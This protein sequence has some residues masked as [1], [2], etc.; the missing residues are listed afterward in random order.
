MRRLAL[1]LAVLTLAAC[2]ALP[3]P[4]AA[5][6][7]TF[8]DK[9][10]LQLNVAKLEIEEAAGVEMVPQALPTASLAPADVAR[11]WARQRIATAGTQGVARFR[12]LEASVVDTTLPGT[13]HMGGFE[14]SMQERSLIA[15]LRVD[16]VLE[17]I[18][19]ERRALGDATAERRVH[20]TLSPAEREA[21]YDALLGDLAR[22]FDDVMT[23]QVGAALAGF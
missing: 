6:A 14:T 11:S 23:A 20:G 7:I 21:Q 18:G 22:R 8:G 2:A 12:I 19:N 1:L 9:P 5:P 3:Q 15:R 4:N 16:L 13:G 10:R 17:G